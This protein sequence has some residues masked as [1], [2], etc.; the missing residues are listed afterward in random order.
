MNCSRCKTEF[1]VED[2]FCQGCGLNLS[3]NTNVDKPFK[4]KSKY[5]LRAE[6]LELSQK[7]GFLLHDDS[8]VMEEYVRREV[9]MRETQKNFDDGLD[10]LLA[11]IAGDISK[12]ER[13]RREI[14]LW[15]KEV[16]R[17]T[18]LKDFKL[19][20]E[21]AKQRGLIEK[22]RS[23]PGKVFYVGCSTLLLLIAILKLL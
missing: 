5:L 22:S 21:E 15:P 10:S 11:A 6:A 20:E 4:G 16:N 12:E 3:M 2:S 14:E 18:A 9:T 17:E 23:T 8:W 19:I 1:T 13:S 7:K